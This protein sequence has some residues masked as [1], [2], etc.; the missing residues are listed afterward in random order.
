M[1]QNIGKP[2]SN[3]PYL[4]WQSG[5]ALGQRF[6][7]NQDFNLIGSDRTYC[8]IILDYDLIS[9]R[10]ATLEI[11]QSGTA[12]LV[13]LASTNGTFVNGER[14]TRQQLTEGDQIA[15]GP[16]GEFIF[17]YHTEPPE[18]QGAL[19]ETQVV[20]WPLLREWTLSSVA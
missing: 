9:R 6:D 2:G 8:Q 4:T 12:T 20:P 16:T 19:P 5:V 14:V 7:I 13:D 17:T 11:D 18:P 3:R 10:H 1:E 15:F